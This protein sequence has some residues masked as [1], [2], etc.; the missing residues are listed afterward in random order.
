MAAAVSS[1][2]VELAELRLRLRST[3]HD[4]ARPISTKMSEFRMLL[5]ESRRCAAAASAEPLLADS[6]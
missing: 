3:L 4:S 2:D 5:V 1:M 6:L